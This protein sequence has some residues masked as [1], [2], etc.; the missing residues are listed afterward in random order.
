MKEHGTSDAP[1]VFST[2]RVLPQCWDVLAG[3]N[4]Y[5]KRTFLEAVEAS[6][7]LGQRYYLFGAPEPDSL[8]VSFRW[9]LQ[10]PLVRFPVSAT[11][12]GVPCGC[13]RGGLRLGPRGQGSLRRHLR[14]TPG[15]KL[16]L[17]S[18]ADLGSELA[19]VRRDDSFVLK[20]RWDTF[21]EYLHSMRSGY[22][23]RVRTAL[24][25]C[26]GLTVERVS[27]ATNLVDLLYPLYVATYRRARH[28]LMQLDPR[29]L[30]SLP[31]GPRGETVVVRNGS[32]RP[33]AFAQLFEGDGQLCFF[34][35]GLDYSAL[36]HT[37]DLYVFLLLQLVRIAV[38]G[39]YH[40]LELGKDAG[41][42]KMRLGCQPRPLFSFAGH[43]NPILHRVLAAYLGRRSA[44]DPLPA[45][46]VFRG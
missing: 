7:R 36:E 11:A 12:V 27:D 6:H 5:L 32:S 2:A 24:R 38:D 15:L 19:C 25:R 17:P 23:R 29:L 40:S 13:S 30:F 9:R 22:R 37:A 33:V 45:C 10:V 43:R 1:R 16:V 26:R 28:R 14:E 35:G 31:P 42:A 46:H 21:D 44:P 41:H 20:I 34:K 8:L 3:T 18:T 4:V 39:G